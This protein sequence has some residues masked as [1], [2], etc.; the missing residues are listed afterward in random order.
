MSHAGHALAARQL[1]ALAA[2]SN[3]VVE[4]LPE[5][6]NNDNDLVIALDL[7]D[8]PRG[9]GIKVRSRERFRLIIP[10]TFPFAPPAV[11]VLHGRWRGTPHVNWGRHLCLYAASSVEWNPSDGIR[12]LLDRLVTWLER[13]AAGTLD[14][15]GQPLHPPAAFPSAQAGHLIVHPD[16]GARTPWRRHAGPGP[17]ISYAWCVSSPGRIEVVQWLDELDAFHRVL[18]DDV[19]AVDEQGRPYLLIPAM[20]VDDQITWEYPSSARELAAGLESVGYPRD[21]LLRDLTWAS[22]LNRLLRWAEDPDTD[23]P[24]TDP[25]VMLLGTPS[26]RVEG[27]TRLAHLVAWNLDAFGAEVASMLGRAKVLD[28]KEIT[29]RVL[30]RAHQWLD[31]AKVRWMTVHEARPEVARRRDEGTALSWIRGKR[32]LVLGAGALGAPI[33]EHCVRAG[34]KTL[35][36]IDRGT[37]NPGILV[38]QPYTYNDIGQ[39]KA[40]VLAARLNTLAPHPTTTAAHRDAVAVFAAG[41]FA[42]ENVDLIIDATADVGVRSALERTRKS[43]RDDWPPVATMIIGHRADH[44]LLTV[45][46]PGAAGAGHDVLRRTS[47]RARGPQ[48]STWNDIADDFFPDPPRTEMFFPEPGCSAPTFVG[49]AAELGNL[50]SSM[51]IQAVQIISAGPGHQAAMTAA[52]VR[53][54]SANAHPTPATPLLT[55]DDDLVCIDP[56]SGYEVRI[57]AD[58]LTQMQIETRRGA[59]VRGPEIETGGMLLGAFDDAVGVVHIDAATGPPPDSLLSQTYFEHGVAGAQELL[60]HHHRRTNGLTTFTGMWHTHPCGSARPSATDEAG[61]TTITSLS[62][63]SR[64]ALM[65]ILGGPEPVWNAWRDG[66]GAPHLYARIVENRPSANTLAAP[67]TMAPPPGRYFSGGY[68]YPPAETSGS[69][70]RRRTWTWRRR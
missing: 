30:N 51:L 29:G 32:I 3:G 15:D 58:A 64:R 40:Y 5:H 55:W 48:A 44:G 13:A 16:L 11:A 52:A 57:C 68:A 62:Q 23:D 19:Q 60:D 7:R 42:A 27:D 63:G 56:E 12:G 39:S 34:A 36:I 46:A 70:R 65:L 1:A 41:S 33:A 61:M 25:V 47:I 9:P 31:T 54:P 50:A 38:R 69:A 17:S 14:P 35:S 18:A 6:A 67:A 28:D 21:R 4:V 45:S 2:V 10:E 53:R 66:A 22:S 24:D 26:R 59:R 43:R 49:S 20:L 37:V 8:I